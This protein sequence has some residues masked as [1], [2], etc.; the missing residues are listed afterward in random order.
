MLFLL[1][2]LSQGV[3]PIC[4]QT[5]EEPHGKAKERVEYVVLARIEI[6]R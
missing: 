2:Y 3:R 5:L 1:L 6:I 4:I